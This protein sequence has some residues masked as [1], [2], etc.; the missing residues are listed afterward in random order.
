MRERARTIECRPRTE[1]SL[2]RQT[3]RRRATWGRRLQTRSKAGTWDRRPRTEGLPGYV[4]IEAGVFTM[5]SPVGE[6]GRCGPVGG[7]QDCGSAEFNEVEH[8]VTLSRPFYL[9]ATEVTQGEWNEVMHTSP[10]E[11]GN[12]GLNCPVE[13]VSWNGAVDYC[14]ALSEDEGLPDCYNAN[15]EFVGGGCLGYRLPTEAE[16]E[17]AAR[18]G[19]TEATYE[20]DLVEDACGRD[21]VLVNIAWY[22]ENSGQTPHPV[23]E[24]RPNAWGLSDMLGN[25]YEWTNDGWAAYVG[26]PEPDPRGPQPAGGFRVF[27][28]GSW[29]NYGRSARA[30][31][32]SSGTPDGSGSDA[33]LRPARSP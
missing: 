33:G 28:G 3:P 19:S 23:G 15:R 24:K 11:S 22:C 26:G 25:V 20:G 8:E 31:F 14:N 9:K 29:L 4:L 7:A 18:A 2:R 32:R 12:C 1:C 16:W 21:A 6:V 17:Y 5:G 13:R 30:A 27:R 10:S